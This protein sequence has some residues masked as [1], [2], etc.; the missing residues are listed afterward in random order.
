MMAS[1]LYGAARLPIAAR[2]VLVSMSPGDALAISVFVV[3]CATAR[4][5]HAKE[6]DFDGLIPS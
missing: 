2:Q 1:G 6:K 5:V 4:P 3:F